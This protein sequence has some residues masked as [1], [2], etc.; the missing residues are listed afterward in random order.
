M[1]RTK[2]NIIVAIT[3]HHNEMLRISVRAL[4]RLRSEFLLMIYNDNPSVRLTARCVR[5]MGYRGRLRIING[6][7]DCG[8]L[9][10][11]LEILQDIKHRQIKSDWIIFVNSGDVLR[12]VGVPVVTPD[13]FAVVQS[14]VVL[15]GTMLDCLR[16]V[17]CP[18]GYDFNNGE[19]DMV[20]PN[21]GV[22][23]TPLR[24]SVMVGLSDLL[25]GH[26]DKIAGIDASLPSAVFDTIMWN[27]AM[28]FV[29]AYC[30]QMTPIYMDSA[31]YLVPE[32]CAQARKVSAAQIARIVEYSDSIFQNALAAAP[33][34]QD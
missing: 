22:A 16:F 17:E 13:I 6:C 33:S 18:W 12:S 24:T 21:L 8:E 27:W 11:R 2:N 10:S 14:R 25:I 29:R 23:G 26:M 7:R 34:G 15:R 30:P 4:S 5:R 19:F 32:F 3:T 9:L 1:L 31:N 28:G 20:C